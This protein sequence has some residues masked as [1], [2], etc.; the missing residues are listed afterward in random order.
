MS[1]PPASLVAGVHRLAEGPPVLGLVLLPDK[2]DRRQVATVCL[3][4]TSICSG[5]SEII[6]R[7]RAAAGI[8]KGRLTSL[9]CL[10]A[11]LVR[12]SSCSPCFRRKGYDPATGRE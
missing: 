3:S 8:G 1:T 4:A 11:L 5:T 6:L 7:V 9:T 2:I 10:L 12:P